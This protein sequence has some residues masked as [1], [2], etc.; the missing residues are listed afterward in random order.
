MRLQLPPLGPLVSLI[1]VIDIAKQETVC[2]SM[3]DKADVFAD[4]YRIELG[5]PWLVE[6]V[7][8]QAGLRR[9]QL[10]IE[11]SSLNGFLLLARHPGEA[12]GKRIRDP[13]FHKRSGYTAASFAY[14]TVHCRGGDP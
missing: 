3:N 8:L 5:I 12:V 2:G 7:E 9:I 14:E 13:E 1:V 11:C 10:K 4:A 6:L